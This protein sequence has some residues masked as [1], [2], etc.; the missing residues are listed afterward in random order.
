MMTITVET[1]L[2]SKLIDHNKPHN[3]MPDHTQNIVSNQYLTVIS[4]SSEPTI[5][6]EIC[7]Q[8]IMI[9]GTGFFTYNLLKL[10][11]KSIRILH[12]HCA[13]KETLK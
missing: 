4:K 1:A 6:H 8:K 13:N 3:L 2:N 5:A 9:F 7:L 10:R 12:R 11:Q